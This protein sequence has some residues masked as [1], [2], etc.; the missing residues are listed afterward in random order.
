MD[1][2]HRTASGTETKT[3]P[4]LNLILALRSF[5]EELEHVPAGT[6]RHPSPS[7]LIKQA[8]EKLDLL[9]AKRMSMISELETLRAFNAGRELSDDAARMA[10]LEA[11]SPAT[12]MQ[13]LLY[14]ITT[15]DPDRS[16]LERPPVI[17]DDAGSPPMIRLQIAGHKPE[18]VTIVMHRAG[19]V[20]A[21]DV[22]AEDFL[23]REDLPEK[24][25]LIASEFNK[26]IKDPGVAGIRFD[27]L[28]AF[29][30]VTDP[31]ER[32]LVTGYVVEIMDLY[33]G[34]PGATIS[35][36][37]RHFAEEQLRG[38]DKFT[39]DIPLD[40]LSDLELVKLYAR[41]LEDFVKQESRRAAGEDESSTDEEAEDDN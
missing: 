24:L 16:D 38:F 8:A 39:E 21:F 22:R 33:H 9:E 6:Y 14:L 31:V 7:R 18:L 32:E 36:E 37:A 40:H 30:R 17:E 23:T 15:G 10:F 20:A 2:G 26:N 1:N 27:D 19:Y 11:M 34:R 4:M 25:E 5:A 29:K 13:H 35:P 3:E 41:A 12:L 28:P